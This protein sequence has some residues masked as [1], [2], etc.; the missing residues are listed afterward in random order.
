MSEVRGPADAADRFR[1]LHRPGDP[2]LLA[3]AWDAASARIVAAQG[4]PAVATSSVAVAESL[5]HAD[6]GTAPATEMFAAAA[7]IA[8][9]VDV[10]VTVDA[11][12]GYRLPPAALVDALLAAGAVGCNIEDSTGAVL[13]DVDDQAARLA[14]IRKAA[15]DAGVPLVLN[16]RVDVFLR[17]GDADEADVVDAAIARANR[18]LAAGADCAYPIGCREPDTI[19][20]LVDGIDGPVNVHWRPAGP[21]PAVLATLGVARISTGGLLWRAAMDAYRDAVAALRD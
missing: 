1:S 21:T 4:F 2:V 8:A 10:P 14:G 3:N 5:G 19:A 9:A 16:A 7:R 6:G 20:R 18:Y 17:R 13:S 11:E 15:G 12:D